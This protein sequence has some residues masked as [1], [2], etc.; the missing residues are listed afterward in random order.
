MKKSMLITYKIKVTWADWGTL[1]YEK[2]D[3]YRNIMK[4]VN[5]QYK[6]EQA[7]AVEM[8]L[9]NESKNIDKKQKV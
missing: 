4:F 6:I 5:N 7:D 9:I 3:T 2:V 1:I 8:E